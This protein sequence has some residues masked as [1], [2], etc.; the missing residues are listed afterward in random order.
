MNEPLSYIIFYTVCVFLGSSNGKEPAC[1]AGDLGLISGSGR[2]PGEGNV[3]TLQ[4]SYLENHMGR[5][6]WWASP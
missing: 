3:N 1:S 5:E 2:F 4:Y 6:A